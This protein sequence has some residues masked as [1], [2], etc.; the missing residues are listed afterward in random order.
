MQKSKWKLDIVIKKKNPKQT[1]KYHCQKEKRKGRQNQ[2]DDWRWWKTWRIKTKVIYGLKSPINEIN[3]SSLL[4][5]KVTH[6]CT[7]THTYPYTFVYLFV[8]RFG[9]FAVLWKM[10]Y[11]LHAIFLVQ[12]FYANPQ[13]FHH[14]LKKQNKLKCEEQY[15]YSDSC[16]WRF[17]CHLIQ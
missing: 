1:K 6:T 3:D 2:D 4:S 14:N 16:L 11:L 17:P 5:L 15:C 8:L 10:L 9:I 12:G 13:I 7:H